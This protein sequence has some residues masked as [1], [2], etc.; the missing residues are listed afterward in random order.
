VGNDADRIGPPYRIG[1]TRVDSYSLRIL[2]EVPCGYGCWSSGYFPT[3]VEFISH[4]D[5]GRLG[6]S[7]VVLAVTQCRRIVGRHPCDVSAGRVV[8]PKF[9]DE[10]GLENRLHDTFEHNDKRRS[11][12]SGGRNTVLLIKLTCH[13]L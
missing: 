13:P 2:Y 1:F 3:K 4:Q 6:E 12:L 10:K 5:I 7:W 9:Y 11:V 8:K